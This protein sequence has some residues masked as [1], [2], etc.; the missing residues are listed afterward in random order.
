MSAW[1]IVAAAGQGR[2]FGGPKAFVPLARVPIVSHSLHALASAK[3]IDGIVV[4]L[5]QEWVDRAPAMLAATLPST[6]V[7]F[8][9]G[10]A[11]RRESV[12]AGIERVPGDV[13]AIVVHD[14]ARPL[15]TAELVERVLAALD[16]ASGA[17]VAVPESDT[18][19]RVD[20]EL[21][22]TTVDRN[23]LWRAQTPQAFRA[24]VLRRAHA[25][26]D[27]DGFDATD[28]ASLVERLGETVAIVPGDP[29]NLK[30]TSP[31]DLAIAEALLAARARA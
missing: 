12:R 18:L 29:A 30:V 26:A 25:R 14:A 13:E 23:G 15:V 27:E 20:G 24:E 1:A 10:G 7:R 2:R 4:V 22:V 16:L 8:A 31:G 6:P 28:D 3:Q 11:S 19:K 17:I 21:V 5:A 9:A